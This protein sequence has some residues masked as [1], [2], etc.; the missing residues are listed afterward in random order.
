MVMWLGVLGD[1]LTRT[2]GSKSFCFAVVVLHASYGR[3]NGSCFFLFIMDLDKAT[4]RER[5]SG[6]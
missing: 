4:R 6:F 3:G 5:F 1:E 2:K